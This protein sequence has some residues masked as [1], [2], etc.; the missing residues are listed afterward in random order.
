MSSDN[1]TNKNSNFTNKNDN[2]AADKIKDEAKEDIG[3]VV[4]KV[5]AGGTAVVKKVFDTDKD[6]ETEYHK[7]KGAENQAS[8]DAATPK[9]I[10]TQ[11][12]PQYKK[13]LV[14]HDGSELSDKA[15][16]HALRV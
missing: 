6:L 14:P 11:N 2:D 1:R 5:K 7:A 12:I 16:A 8:S 13:I 3:D 15:L 10:V 4:N 9:E